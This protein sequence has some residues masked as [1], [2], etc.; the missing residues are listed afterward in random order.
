MFIISVSLI[1]SLLDAIIFFCFGISGL[2]IYCLRSPSVYFGKH[3]IKITKIPY[4]IT[5]QYFKL[6]ITWHTIILKNIVF[7][8][9]TPCSLV[10]IYQHFGVTHCLHLQNRRVCSNEISINI[11]QSVELHIPQDSILQDYRCVTSYHRFVPFLLT[12]WT[13]GFH[14]D[15]TPEVGWILLLTQGAIREACCRV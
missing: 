2:Y 15:G 7:W 12:V 10:Q 8:Y 14:V 3:S 1:H 6:T 4:S 9:L 13:A 11:C 5:I